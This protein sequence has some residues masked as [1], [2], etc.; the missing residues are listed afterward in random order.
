MTNDA[1]GNGSDATVREFASGQKLF[2]RYTLKRTLGRGGMGIVWLARDDELER[3]VALKFLP[4]LI[5]HDRA[6]LSDLKRETRRSLE[7]TH[8]NI[9]RIYDFIHDETNGC[10]SME[11][12][13][14]D[15]LSNLRADKAHK[16]FEPEELKEWISELCDALDYAHNHARIVHRDLKPSN[17]MVNQRGDLKVA[18]F[19]IARSLSDSMSMLTMDRGKSGTLLYMSPQQLD[20]ER[21]NHL[22]DVYSLGASVY[23]LLTSK[24]PFY[25]GNVDR[26]IREKVPPTMTQRRKD[27]EINGDEPVDEVWEDVVRR[28]LAKDPAKRPQSVSEI[29]KMLLVPS[30]KTRR[31]KRKSNAEGY[32]KKWIGVVAAVIVLSMLVAGGWFIFQKIQKPSAERSTSAPAPL[33]PPI[34]A[35]PPSAPTIAPPAFGLAVIKTTPSGATITIDNK[36]QRSPAT[37]RQV[38]PGRYPLRVELSGYQAVEQQIDIREN[39]TTDLGTIAL[40]QIKPVETPSPL[41]QAKVIPSS[42]YTGTIAI[43]GQAGYSVPVTITPSSDLRSGTMSQTGKRGELVV[44]YTGVWDGD[45]LRA[46][47][48]EVVSKPNGI[49][50]EPEAFTLQFSGDGKTATYECNAEGKIYFANL[51]AR[52]LGSSKGA[53][54]RPVYKGTTSTG[55]PLTITF[56]A[57][58]TSGR[59]TESSKSGDVVVK[60][61]GIWDGGILRAVTNEVISKSARVKWEPESFALHFSDDGRSGSYESHADGKVYTAQLSP[62]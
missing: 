9:V 37:F 27:F 13:D 57:D 29:A 24:P 31:A 30:P 55:T 22:D 40:K 47:T 50:W 61:T 1:P 28:C 19:G 59:M 48:S 39:Q 26:Q 46:V 62:P 51:I 8:K 36:Q 4:D 20:G 2:R 38:K 32:S 25:S 42:A 6:V 17:L 33:A 15:T 43:R 7:L 54:L 44:K 52:Q 12:V 34:P 60:F 11:Y 35:A 5:I 23:E 56:N 14:G 58:R 3:E 45:A 53:T 18:D 16:V 49:R 41:N 21:G 10:I